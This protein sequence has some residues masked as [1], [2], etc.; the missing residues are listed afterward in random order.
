MTT[1]EITF[2]EARQ[3]V[4]RALAIESSDLRKWL[5]RD[6][7]KNPSKYRDP[8]FVPA[9]YTERRDRMAIVASYFKQFD[10]FV[11]QLRHEAETDRKRAYSAGFDA[12]QKETGGGTDMLRRMPPVHIGKYIALLKNHYSK[13]VRD[14][15]K[16]R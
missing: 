13:T 9:W 12:G 3:E 10:E 16:S 2:D 6:R 8:N 7:V 15:V 11:Q 4:Y 14:E 5:E 1:N